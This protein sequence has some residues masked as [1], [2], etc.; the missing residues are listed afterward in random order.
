MVQQLIVAVGAGLAAAILFIVPVK[1]TMAAMMLAMFS[2]LP[3][4]IAGLAFAPSVALVAAIAGMAGTALVLHP[5]PAM[6][7]GLW[8]ALPAW[9]LTRLAW[10][11]RPPQAGESPDADGMVWYPIGR[12]VLWAAGLGAAA[13][14]ALVI[15]GVMHFGSYSEFV[16][17]T[18]KALTAMFEQLL[19][20]PNA[21]KTPR[22][23]S[24]AELASFFLRSVLPQLAAWGCFMLSFN[25]WFGAR[26]AR[27]S[28]RLTR[29]WP[30][31][32]MEL[33]LPR[34]L[35]F[36]LAVALLASF[37]GGLARMLAA[38]TVAA[39]GMA[40]CLQGF[41]VIHVVSRGMRNRTLNLTLLYMLNFFLMPVPLVIT[42]LLGVADAYA[43]FRRR[44]GQPPSP[45]AQ[46]P[47]WPPPANSN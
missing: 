9:W 23:L 12:L 11:A 35:V 30:D 15:A 25:L 7:F 17:Q 47:P 28:Q 8:A 5:L 26:I 41:A 44:F 40:F 13:T 27:T 14:I 19:K 46:R 36:V 16:A 3:I 21:P 33:R 31:I 20:S 10:L 2:P 43:D 37:T 1:G 45:P 6:V 39:A 42:A 32:A 24:P 34:A 22:G 38:I 29:P 18:S 4:M